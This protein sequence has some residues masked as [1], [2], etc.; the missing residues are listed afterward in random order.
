MGLPCPWMETNKTGMNGKTN[1]Y[2]NAA[3]AVNILP[4]TKL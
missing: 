4:D 3:F 1:T 2:H